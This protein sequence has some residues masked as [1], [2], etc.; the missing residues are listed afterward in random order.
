MSATLNVTYN[1]MS[2]D[3]C[4]LEYDTQDADVVRIAEESLELTP[5]T[6]QHFVVDRFD[7]PAGGQRIYLRPKVPFGAEVKVRRRLYNEDNS[8]TDEGMDIIRRI[9]NS[10]HGVL[11][12]YGAEVDLRDLQCI[13]HQCDCPIT[14]AII[15]DRLS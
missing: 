11:R 9:E 2:Q 8:I 6:L 15:S 5:G 3:V 1:G 10:V 7:T 4:H 12:D 14:G 13:F